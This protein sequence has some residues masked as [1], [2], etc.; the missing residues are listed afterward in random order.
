MSDFISIASSV[1]PKSAKVVGFRGTEAFS[2]PFHVEIFFMLRGDD[3]GELDLADAIG[4]KARLVID[5]ADDNIPPFYFSG[6]LATIELQHAADNFA[7]FRAVLVPRLYQLSLSRHSRI[8]TKVTVVDAIEAILQDNGLS[9]SDYELRLQGY[10]TEEHIT[11]YRESDLDFISRWMEREGIFYFFEHTED[12]DKVIFC[13]HLTYD[14][15]KL[16]KPVRYHPQLGSDRS[17]GQSFRSFSAR[18]STLPTQIKL[19]DYDYAKPNLDVSG[20]AKVDDNGAG[21]VNLYGER[22]FSPGAGKRLATLRAEEMLAR[23]VVY[24]ANGTRLHLRP[25]YKF[26]IEDHPI[27]S[28]NMEYVSIETRHEGNQAAEVPSIRA[29]IGITQ[30]D[31]YHVEVDAIAATT[32]F[33]A[34]SR[35]QWPRIYGFENGTVDGAASSE[36]AQIDDQG[37]YNVKFR[38]DES[39]LKSGKASTWVRMMQPHGGGIEGFHFPLRKGTEVAISFLGGDPDRPVITG[40]VPNALTPSPVTSGNHTKNVIQTGGRNRLELEDLAGQQRITM[41]TPY[42]NTYV[43]MG[44]PNEQHEL[45]V[46]TDENALVDAALAYDTVVG[47]DPGAA[48]PAGDMTVTVKNNLK[49]TV[50]N[51]NYDTVV[52]KG[53]MSTTV[54]LGASKHEVQKVVTETYHDDQ[55]TAVTGIRRLDVA[56]QLQV[57]STEHM[58]LNSR[59]QLQLTSG[60]SSW[61]TVESGGM[62]ETIAGGW[63]STISDGAVTIT[64]TGGDITIEATGSNNLTIRANKVETTNTG[65]WVSQTFGDWVKLNF[66]KG[67]ELNAALKATVT[68]GLQSDTFVGGQNSNF[69]GL[70]LETAIAGVL[71]YAFGVGLKVNAA[72]EMNMVPVKTGAF[73]MRLENMLMGL[74]NHAASLEQNG[75]KLIG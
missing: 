73:Q 69:V 66:N 68:V 65:D 15:D 43:R 10:E 74:V 4:A 53:D 72:F 32:Q 33:R 51:Q 62:H 46:H 12:G 16:G 31:V 14:S 35:T 17:A 40:V 24:R 41:S 8:F 23:K 48:S 58:F 47:V 57:H 45:I 3:T 42:A 2:R 44:S 59:Q 39:D 30:E 55:R 52:E 70:K 11:Q 67:L 18:F 5:R 63:S 28:M 60:Q 1:I 25:G 19:R 38:F 26:E 49:T 29:L 13:D 27:A 21:E 64:S 50:K 6:I 22:F 7:L 20:S 71:A 34:E 61:V 37:R 54:T 9:G 36:Y 75:F 56:K